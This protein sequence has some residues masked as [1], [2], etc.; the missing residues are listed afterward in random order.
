M[1]D[2]ILT[3]HTHIQYNIEHLFFNNNNDVN[4][5]RLFISFAGKVNFYVNPTWFYYNKKVVGNFL[6]LKNDNEY[7]TYSNDA[8]QNII[9]Y[10]IKKYNITTLISYGLSMGGIASLYYGI[11]FKANLII[12]I[13]PH[14]IQYSMNKLYQLIEKTEFNYEKIYINYTFNKI[15]S[16]SDSKSDS[17]SS[18]HI[19]IHTEKII[20]KLLHKNVLLTIQPYISSSHLDFVISKQYLNDIII[21]FLSLKV[22]KYNKPLTT[23]I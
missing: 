8:Y 10:Y 21:K 17:N 14:P 22:E 23:L 2:E 20:Q 6:F 7:N 4:N 13:D 12:S 15:Y 1:I 5:N 18:L 19:P 3:K 16:K 11:I 9:Q